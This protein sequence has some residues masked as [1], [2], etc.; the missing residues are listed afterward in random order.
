MRMQAPASLEAAGVQPRLITRWREVHGSSKKPDAGSD[1]GGA[2]VSD[3]QRAFFGFC[4]SWKDVLFTQRPYPIRW[5]C[6]LIHHA[7][8]CITHSQ[9]DVQLDP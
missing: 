8:A 2:F 3:E 1:D 7:L 6:F 9:H 5:D 4:A